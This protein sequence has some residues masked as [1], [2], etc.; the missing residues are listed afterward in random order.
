M[1]KIRTRGSAFHVAIQYL[2]TCGDY[3][4]TTSV[5]IWGDKKPKAILELFVVPLLLL[6]LQY[7][8]CVRIFTD[9]E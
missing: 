8:G 1:H 7:T 6:R 3:L 4:P 9:R 5:I 2:A